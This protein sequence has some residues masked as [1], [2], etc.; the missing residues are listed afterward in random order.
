MIEILSDMGII[1]LVFIL[2]CGYI[3]V[4]FSVLSMIFAI[5]EC[6]KQIWGA[7]KKQLKNRE[8]S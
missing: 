4:S 1:A 3:V 7:I 8:D 6:R 5:F 2:L